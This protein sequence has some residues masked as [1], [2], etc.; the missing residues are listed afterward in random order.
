MSNELEDLQDDLHA[1]AANLRTQSLLTEL[2]L[3]AERLI[4]KRTRQ[5]KDVHGAPFEPYDEDYKKRKKKEGTYAG[6]VNL[7][8]N[9]YRSMLGTLTHDVGPDFEE[10]VLYFSDDKKGE[11]A[12]YHNR[13]EGDNPQREFFAL[14]EDEEAK[15]AKLVGDHLDEQLQLADLD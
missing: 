7:K 9:Q 8:R 13:G 10:V 12:G 6:H 1:L 15:L 3:G 2:G 14:S 11:I 4:K 5:G